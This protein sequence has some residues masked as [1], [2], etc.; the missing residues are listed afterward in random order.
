MGDKLL[1][2]NFKKEINTKNNND[3]IDLVEKKLDF[4]FSF[5]Y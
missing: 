3:V 4:L 5:F 2:I 1:N